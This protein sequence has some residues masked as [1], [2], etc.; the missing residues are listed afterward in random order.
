[1][2]DMGQ[3]TGSTL[4]VGRRDGECMIRWYEKGLQMRD[5]FR[6]GWCRFEIELKP[7]KAELAMVFWLML[8]QGRRDELAAS[9]FSAAFLP[10]FAGA[11]TV[12]KRIDVQP[13]VARSLDDRVLSMVTQWGGLL[14]EMLQRA[15]GD[16]AEVANVLFEAMAEKA[17]RANLIRQQSSGDQSKFEE[18]PY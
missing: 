15:D 1:I 4:Y 11:E 9:G 18:I 14:G 12:D 10:F 5:P 17:R 2:D 3:G 16:R 6:K 13:A 8:K 7:K